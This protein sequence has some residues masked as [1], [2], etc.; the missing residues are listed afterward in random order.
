MAKAQRWWWW[1]LVVARSFPPVS[2]PSADYLPCHYCHAPAGTARTPTPPEK[3]HRPR[4][5]SE[6]HAPSQPLGDQTD[7]RQD[8][9][10]RS[11]S[12]HTNYYLRHRLCLLERSTAPRIQKHAPASVFFPLL[13]ETHQNRP[14]LGV[15][16]DSNLKIWNRG[17]V[18]QTSAPFTDRPTITR[19][20]CLF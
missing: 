1:S 7:T 8:Y 12:T 19:S 15:E 9:S 10:L 16:D 13:P 17:C 14:P 3:P 6:S 11:T 2:A 18:T 4:S 20:A 5:D